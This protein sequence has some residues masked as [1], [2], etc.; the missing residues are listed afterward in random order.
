NWDGGLGADSSGNYNTFTAT[1]LVATDQMEDAPSNNF[2]TLNPL[3]TSQ[4]S[5]S[6]RV[7]SAGNLKASTAASNWKNVATTQNITSGKWYW[8]IREGA[9][10]YNTEI[11][12]CR[13]DW[14]TGGTAVGP[15]TAGSYCVY[16][17]GSGT[18]GTF[19]D[20]THTVNN[21]F[22]WAEN[23]R[24]MCAYDDDT[25]KFWLGKNGT[26]FI[27]GDPAAGSNPS[28]TVNADD[29]GD[30]YPVYAYYHSDA[31]GRF[32]FGAD[33]SFDGTVTAQGNQDGNNVGDFYYAPPSGFLALCTSNLA[34]PEIA[35]PTTK[36]NT[37]LYTGN[38][39]TNVIT[40]VGFQPEL[41]W[42]K[43]R[44]T[45]GDYPVIVDAVR[46]KTEVWSS[47]SYSAEWTDATAITSFDSDGFTL[48]N[49]TTDWNRTGGS[50]VAWNWLAG[51]TPTTDNVAS[52]GATPTAGS[53]KIDGSDLGSALAG[54]EPAQ[55]ISANT[56]TGFSIILYDGTAS[57]GTTFAHG[58][59]EAPEFILCKNLIQGTDG[60]ANPIVLAVPNMTTGSQKVLYLDG[61]AAAAVEYDAFSNTAPTASVFSVGAMYATNKSGSHAMV[62]YCF[63]SIEGFSKIGTYE[64]NGNNN[65]PFV[66]TGF[67]P[68]YILIRRYDVGNSWI[69]QDDA[70]SPYNTVKA[71]LNADDNTDEYTGWTGLDMVSNGFKP[72]DGSANTMN[73]SGGDYVYMAFASSPFKYSNAR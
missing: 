48:G 65:G 8:E 73:A 25:G 72:R 61:A 31:F 58:L 11:G 17:S 59:S 35:D 60:N 44:T 67:R 19:V 47:A 57:G 20:A 32:N 6:S 69:I 18:G 45:T 55:R 70:R 1:N 24:L 49:A 66:Y 41:L 9:S 50:F 10:Q 52:A 63:H 15:E 28:F 16:C 46:G 2:A 4:S 34:A 13:T 21:N 42:V 71:W 23:D 37:V 51:G 53:V 39:T 64:G 3:W 54:N 27:S 62:A 33:S 26:W 29:R 56:E 5:D 68:A 12:V 36:F 30:V 7:F 22:V 38:Q 14:N 40:G 43:N